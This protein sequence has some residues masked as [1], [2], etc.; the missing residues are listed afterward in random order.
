MGVEGTGAGAGEGGGRGRRKEAG[1][2]LGYIKVGEDKRNGGGS[3]FFY[4]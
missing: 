3:Y 4:A 2:K 1:S